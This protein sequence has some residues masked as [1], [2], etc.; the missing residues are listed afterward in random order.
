MFVPNREIL[1]ATLI[2]AR[3]SGPKGMLGPL[4][5]RAGRELEQ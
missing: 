1:Q 4:A 5:K 3:D 2:V